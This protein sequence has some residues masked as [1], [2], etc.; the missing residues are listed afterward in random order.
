MIDFYHHPDGKEEMRMKQ[1]HNGGFSLIE[2]VVAIAILGLIVVPSC[3]GLLMAIRINE[4]AQQM[5]QAQ[6]AV[7]SAVETLMAEGIDRTIADECVVKN[8]QG[9]VIIQNGE[10]VIVTI[11]YDDY[12]VKF[13][14]VTE[15]ENKVWKPY[16][17]KDLDQEQRVIDQY[18]GVKVSVTRDPS[19]VFATVTVADDNDL[20]QVDTTIRTVPSVRKVTQEEVAGQ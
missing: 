6:L 12:V 17:T 10:I 5:M 11:A 4:K 19:G 20:V 3:S 9:E 14:E 16:A 18:P 7:S 15:G 2:T 1:K 8:E 13:A